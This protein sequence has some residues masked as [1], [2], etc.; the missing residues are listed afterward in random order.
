MEEDYIPVDEN[1]EELY[2]LTK[3]IEKCKPNH[4]Y[5][6]TIREHFIIH[7]VIKG[8][9][10]YKT[11]TSMYHLSKGHFFIIFPEEQTFYQADK[12][13]PWEYTWIGFN[14]SKAASLLEVLGI[15]KKHPVGEIKDFDNILI[16]VEKNLNLSPFEEIARMKMVGFLYNLFTHLETITDDTLLGQTDKYNKQISYSHEAIKYIRQNYQDENFKIK[17]ISNYLALNESYLSYIFRQVT[18][19][20][21][22]SYLVEFRIQKSRKLLETTDL[23]VKEI[24][25]KVGYKNPLSF[26]RIFKQIMNMPPSEY[27]K[28]NQI[29]GSKNKPSRTAYKRNSRI[30]YNSIL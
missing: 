29:I 4:S 27:K 12:S 3:G 26:T 15:D 7:M 18:G 5:G 6:P 2:F 19:Q 9:G 11:D 25:E 13:D 22:H 17:D 16:E 28:T 10:I 1:F 30:N 24:S 23:T 20:T 14:G 21:L 8:K